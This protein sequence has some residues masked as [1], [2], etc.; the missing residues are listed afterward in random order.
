MTKI[1]LTNEEIAALSRDEI[2]RLAE[3]GELVP[4]YELAKAVFPPKTIGPTWQVN[5]DGSWYLPERTLGW[6]VIGWCHTWLVDPDTGNPWRFTPEQLRFIMWFYEVDANGKRVSTKAM[7][8]RLKGWGKDP[9]AVALGMAELVGPVVFDGWKPNGQPKGR[10]R[11]T[12]LVQVVAVN[13]DQGI[14]NAM[15]LAPDMIPQKTIDEYNLL[16]QV[17]VV[18]IK[19]R[20]GCRFEAVSSSHRGAEGN[21]PHFAILDEPHHWTPTRGGPELYETV[22][23][24]V[25]KV[26]GTIL[27]ISN[28][29]VPGEDSVLER[30]RY[31]VDQFH[32]GLGKDPRWLYD[33]LEANPD[34]PFDSTWGVHVVKMC[35]GDSWPWVNWEEAAEGFEDTSISASRQQRMWYNRVVSAEDAV[36]TEGEWDAIRAPGL[37]GTKADL[38]AGDEIVLGFDGGRTDDATA[39]VA[40]R[41]RDKLIVP[42]AVWESPPQSAQRRKEDR[43]KVDP[44][45]VSGE[46]HIAFYN[47]QVKAFFADVEGWESFIMQ[48]ALQYGSRLFVGATE[49]DPIGYDMRGHQADI[50]YA[51]EALMQSVLDK[52]IWTNGDTKLRKHALN[53]RRNTDNPYGISFRKESRESPKK[54]DAYAATLLAFMAMRAVLGSKKQDKSGIDRT[55]H[56]H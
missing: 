18:Q 47:Y 10:R 53:A 14:K 31:A 36:Y 1:P 33:T 17:E 25:R 49:K 23:F 16:I 22:S 43:W 13:K 15:H 42:L 19:G 32:A 45:Q 11:R 46:V 51:H 4:T 44:V 40:I 26:K 29:Y 56:Q 50:V 12:S 39:L 24:N 21:R 6:E 20:P 3:A 27:G 2:V 52:T 28:A 41:L 37:T 8:Q 55:M 48:W 35:A 34:A 38:Q 5:E 9:M 30:I 7:F 54:V